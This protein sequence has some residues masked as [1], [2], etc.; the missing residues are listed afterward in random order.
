MTKQD[1]K[2]KIDKSSLDIPWVESPL[3]NSIIKNL[4]INNNDLKL[5]KKFNNDGYIIVDL[6]LKDSFIDKIIYEIDEKLEKGKVKKN[7]KIYHYNKSPRIVEAWK[8]SKNVAKLSLNKK[9]LRLLKLFYNKKPIAISSLNFIRGTEQPLHSDYMHFSTI[10]ERFLAG[11]WVA[12]E[13]TNKKNGPLTVVPKSHKLP[14]TDYNSLG[15]KMPQSIEDL[16]K[17]YNV[18]EDYVREVVKSNK[19]KAKEI[20][21]KKGQA[22]IWAA[23]LLHGGSKTLNPKLTRKSQVTHYHFED[24]NKYFNPAFSNPFAGKYASRN[25]DEI[26]I[27]L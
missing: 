27:I 6:D 16:K 15:L 24:C 19:L 12:L 8:F 21:I 20:Y 17:C 1:A 18:Y 5:A 25:I 3:F 11:S 4:K 26:K 14:I 13:D 23:N 2:F 10:P 22:I 7:P 9:I